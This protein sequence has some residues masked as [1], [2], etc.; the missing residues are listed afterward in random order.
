MRKKKAAVHRKTATGKSNHHKTGNG[1]VASGSGVGGK[2]DRPLSL[3]TGDLRLRKANV[4]KSSS[5]RSSGSQYQ[6]P[7]SNNIDDEQKNLPAEELL[8]L[9]QHLKHISNYDNHFM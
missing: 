9:G 1:S 7:S 8:E 6:T 3:T 4:T 5:L 2:L